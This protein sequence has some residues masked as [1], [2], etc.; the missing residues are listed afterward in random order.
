MPAETG[1]MPTPGDGCGSP[2]GSWPG[3]TGPS[4]G[5]ERGSSFQPPDPPLKAGGD[6]G[7]VDPP[8]L[9][10]TPHGKDRANP[11]GGRLPLV[12]RP[13]AVP[14]VAVRDGRC[15]LFGQV[16]GE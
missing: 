13:V 7:R 16:G 12:H 11:S 3:L 8:G 15:L 4:G 1:L 5:G 14:A 6:E 10:V 2:S 9:A